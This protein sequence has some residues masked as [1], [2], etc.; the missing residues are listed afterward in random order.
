M[1]LAFTI[2]LYRKDSRINWYFFLLLTNLTPSFGNKIIFRSE[3]HA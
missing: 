2:P 1:Y 3:I